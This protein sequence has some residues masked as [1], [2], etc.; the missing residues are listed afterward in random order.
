MINIEKIWDEYKAPLKQF[1]CRRVSN[2]CD[3]EDLL[4][5]VFYK[6]CLNEN[7]L[8][9]SGKARSWI[10]QITRNTIIDYYRMK[11]DHLDISEVREEKLI[12]EIEGKS[13]NY[14]ISQCLAA[15]V[16]NLPEKY[17]EAIVLTEYKEMSQKDYGEA[18]GISNSGA[19]SRVQRARV[20]LKETLMDCCALEFDSY[21]DIVNYEHKKDNCK[22]C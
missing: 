14:E 20:K 10:Y 21:G 11:Q 9:D 4:Q 19:R 1:I 5:Y 3:V 13:V 17:K 22:F 15:M 18:I 6:I 8:K 12:Q 7:M 2:Q 16:K